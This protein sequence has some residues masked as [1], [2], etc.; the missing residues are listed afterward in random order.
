VQAAVRLEATFVY[1]AGG[2]RPNY[3]TLARFRRDNAAA[4]TAV[5][6][7]TVIL[8]LRLGLARL[9][10]VALDG[11]KLKA[12]M[13]KHKAMGYG[14]MRQRE[15]QLKEEIARLVEEA[16]AQDAAE[17]QEY[18]ADSEGYSVAE[19]LA[20]RLARIQ[21]ARERLEAEQRAE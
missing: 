4:F 1:L 7:E 15:A 8:A 21:A 14:R 9:G 13:S 16:E 10:H 5:F 6:Q 19:E 17:D 18:G 20:R 2:G 3:R 11:P 12:N